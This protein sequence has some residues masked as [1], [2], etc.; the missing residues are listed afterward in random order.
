MEPAETEHRP[1]EA[2]QLNNGVLTDVDVQ[3]DKQKRVVKLTPKAFVEKVERL[4]SD[5]KSVLTKATNLR[6]KI[7]GLMQQRNVKGAKCFC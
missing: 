6:K 2:L 7:Q 1:M 5:R 3:I 4:Q